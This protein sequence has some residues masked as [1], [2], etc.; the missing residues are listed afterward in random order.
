MKNIQDIDKNFKVETKINKPDIEFYSIDSEPFKLH[1][2]FY[3][4]GKYRRLPE[5]VA[6]EV[7]EGV[8][9]LHANTAGGRVRFKT[10]SPY[11]AINVKMT[12]IIRKTLRRIFGSNVIAV[13]G[14]NKVFIRGER[15]F[16]SAVGDIERT[17]YAVKQNKA[18]KT[19]FLVYHRHFF[20]DI[21]ARNQ[22]FNSIFIKHK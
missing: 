13:G 4:N 17:L 19:P 15:V 21:F 20:R 16:S 18:V 5:S 1:G 8:Y 2:V 9:Y 14:K 3:E 22:I 12:P 6:R 11:I 7:S 10:D